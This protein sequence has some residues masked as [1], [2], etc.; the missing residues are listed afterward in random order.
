MCCRHARLYKPRGNT[1]ARG[2]CRGGGGGREARGECGHA[3]L[4]TGFNLRQKIEEFEET[5]DLT[6]NREI[7]IRSI[8]HVC[9]RERPRDPDKPNDRPS[10]DK[11]TILRTLGPGDFDRHW[12]NQCDG[13]AECLEYLSRQHYILS[14]D[15]MP[16]ENMLLPMMEFRRHIGGFGRM[17]E[18]QRAFLE[19]WYWPSVFS[20]RYSTSSNEVMMLD[21]AV[22]ESFAKNEPIPERGYLSKLRLVVTEP[23]DLLGYTKKGVAIYK[24]V[25]NLIG[26]AAKG[27]HGWTSDHAV[28]MAS[29]KLEDHHIYPRAYILGGPKLDMPAED[30]EDAVDSVVNRA[31]IP[32]LLNV[33]IGKRPPQSYLADIA[34]NNPKLKTC[35]SRH[36]IPGAL[37]E[38]PAWNEKF[39]EFLNQRAKAMFD[40]IEKYAAA[41]P[42]SVVEWFAPPAVV[43]AA[44]VAARARL[45]DLLASGKLRT[46]D[47]VFCRKSPD[48]VA[49]IV[50]ESTVEFEGRR[51]SISKWGLEVT[52]WPTINVYQSVFLERTR[53]PLGELR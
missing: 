1:K 26:Y 53:R 20:N 16:S 30:A 46:G 29:A 51:M 31:L 21:C 41:P 27:V 5:S 45:R 4:C 47:R 42:D 9:G 15:W 36:L 44:G 40:L 37:A 7:I 48:K 8:A 28:D 32:K 39:G 14:P 49:V 2:G 11:Q 43:Q 6:L 34:K 50:D 10:I 17:N 52:K 13:Y 18:R 22:M 24:G 23:D 19:F 33:Q 12:K 35:L 38:S 3:K 25:L